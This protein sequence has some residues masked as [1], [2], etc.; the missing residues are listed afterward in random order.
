MRRFTLLVLGSTTLGVGVAL[1]LNSHLGSDGYSTLLAGASRALEVPFVVA[2]VAMAALMISLGWAR[3]IRPGWG[4]IVQPVTVG[5]VVTLG[6]DRLPEPHE[7]P[8]RISQFGLGFLVLCVGIA[9][10]LSADLG[11]GPAEIVARAFDPPLAFVWGYSTLQ[12]VFALI[13]WRLGA[14]L[15][16]GTLLAS[17]AA[18][19]VVTRFS[20][21]IARFASSPPHPTAP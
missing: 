2:T 1:L 19:P 3:G 7:L 18:G 20:P 16:I 10:Y 4:T 5:A 13:G 17:F 11:I 6:L 14:D 8:G 12:L 15:G 9:A 21:V